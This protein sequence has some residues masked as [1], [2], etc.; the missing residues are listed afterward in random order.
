MAADVTIPEN[1][2]VA[3]AVGAAAGTVRQ[4]V[5]DSVSQPDEDASASICPAARK[6]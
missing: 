1:A 5:A 4:R 3:G 2:D 6:I